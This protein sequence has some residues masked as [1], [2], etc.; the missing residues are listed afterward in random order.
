MGANTAFTRTG[1]TVVI[2]AATSAP[3]PT[4]CIGG[5]LGATQY[6]LVNSGTVTVFLGFGT[7]SAEATSNTTVVT[8]SGNAIPLLSNA[9]EIITFQPNAYFSAITASGTATVYVTP[10]DGI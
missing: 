5:S 10:G 9:V 3:A 8:S 1:S 6:R 2:L 7:T 4:Q